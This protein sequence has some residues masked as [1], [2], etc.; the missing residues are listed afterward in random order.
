MCGCSGG[1]NNRSTNRQS[2]SANARSIRSSTSNNRNV[3]PNTQ[4]NFTAA[5]ESLTDAKK[6]IQK[7]RRDAIRRTFGK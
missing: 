4:A 7:L 1:K 5:D 6:R 3:A 2:R